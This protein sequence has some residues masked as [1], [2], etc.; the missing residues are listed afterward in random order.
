MILKFVLLF[1]FRHREKLGEHRRILQQG[2]EVIRGIGNHGMEVQL[3]IHLAHTFAS[4]ADT[5]DK[6]IFPPFLLFLK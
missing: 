6:V 3:V 5:I 2:L 4:K 1:V